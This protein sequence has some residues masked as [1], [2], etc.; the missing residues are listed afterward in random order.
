MFL[1][2]YIKYANIKGFRRTGHILVNTNPFLTIVRSHSPCGRYFF[3][4]FRL[5]GLTLAKE[6]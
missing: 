1:Q 6:D 4:N 5:I 2:N 3:N